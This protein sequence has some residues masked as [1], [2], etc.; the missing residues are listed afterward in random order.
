MLG[1]GLQDE[2][3]ARRLGRGDLVARQQIALRALEP[4]PVDPHRR[5]RRAPYAR[6]RVAERG[7]LG[8]DDDVGAEHH[9]GAAAD[10]P[11]L[12]RRDGRLGRVPELHVGVDEARDHA[13]I[14]DRVPHAPAFSLLG[15][16]LGRPVEA[17]ARAE[18]GTLG[19]EQDDTDGGVGV[20]LVDGG[21]QLVAQRR[22]DRVVLGG[23]RQHDRAHAGLGLRPQRLHRFPVS[24]LPWRPAP[25]AKRAAPASV[26]P[27]PITS[28][29]RRN[30][31]RIASSNGMAHC[32]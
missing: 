8:G 20:G 9:V 24:K 32:S 15:L 6:G 30:S 12:H 13:E 25:A 16:R 31:F 21:P 14:G 7:A 19:A 23:P 22:G 26:S 4:Q 11:A 29:P 18:G 3:D 1:H 10:A 5:G 17:V 2:A 28:A 27:E